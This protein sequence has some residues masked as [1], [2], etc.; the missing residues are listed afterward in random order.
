MI[1]AHILWLRDDPALP[2][3]RFLSGLSAADLSE[4]KHFRDPSRIRSFAQ[5]RLL[6]QRLLASSLPPHAT[7]ML[8]RTVS[9]R[10]A[11]AGVHGWHISLS[12][13]S[14]LVAAMLSEA[15]CG[16]DIEGPRKMAWQKIANRYFS[17]GEQNWLAQQEAKAGPQAF[18]RLWTLKEAAV[19]AMGKGLANHMASM[20][21][22]LSGKHPQRTGDS[23][24]MALRQ[25]IRED[26][27][28]AAAVMTQEP[29]NWHI[30]CLPADQL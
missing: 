18:L 6:L 4:L 30:E 5:S 26:H 22:D 21:F 11:L 28:L 29:V 25:E 15:G 13:G 8:E 10:L 9:G 7:P 19:K 20:A 16:I 17:A 3:E 2:L 23:A 12:H 27:V 1:Q 14:G 24:D